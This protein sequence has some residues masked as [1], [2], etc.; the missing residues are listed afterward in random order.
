[1]Q[2]L[3]QSSCHRIG[4][5]T[6]TTCHDPHA[7]G[8]RDPDPDASCRGC[9]ADVA[10]A[11]RAHSRHEPPPEP[12]P[13]VASEA[14]DAA[15]ARAPGCV[16]CHAPAVVAL[17]PGLLARDHSLGSPHPELASLGVPD[18]C[19][20]CHAGRGAAAMTRALDDWL[21]TRSRRRVEI[22]RAFAV[23]LAALPTRAPEPAAAAT[24]ALRPLL[25]DPDLDP[26][27]RASAAQLLAGFGEAASAALPELA[28]ILGGT[29]DPQLLRKAANAY[30]RLR[31]SDP[32]PLA[33]LLGRAVDWRVRLAAASALDELGVDAGADEL[34]RLGRDDTL[35]S[36]ARPFVVFELGLS[37]LR[38]TAVQRAEILLSE[39]ARLRPD[40][41][42]AWLNLGVVRATLGDQA[43][44]RLAWETVLRLS[45][46]HPLAAANLAAL[47]EGGEDVP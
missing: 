20:A 22:A 14:P 44:A 26:W 6:C 13:P 41:S 17:A 19:T 34:E 21:P 7:G 27:T 18:A 31:A 46:G 33:D 25:A 8:L 40:D 16:D 28:A 35:P 11:G 45:P 37:A 36:A 5:A 15:R 2:A 24:A 1:V 12:V 30:G 3:A 32:A 10:A 38:R 9:H 23:G 29:H 43:G 42:A 39:A 4:G 47:E